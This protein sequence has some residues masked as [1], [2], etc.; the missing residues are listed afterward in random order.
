MGVG[1]AEDH[2][3]LDLLA[4]GGAGDCLLELALT[5]ISPHRIVRSH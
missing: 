1:G 5:E 2:W 4:L 3:P